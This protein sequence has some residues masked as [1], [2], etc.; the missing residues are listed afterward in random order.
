MSS[1]FSMPTSVSNHKTVSTGRTARTEVANLAE[2]K[3]PRDP[4]FSSIET[5][6]R[7]VPLAL[8]LLH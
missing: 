2:R 3:Q 8:D 1:Q 4:G 7:V 6:K 5:C